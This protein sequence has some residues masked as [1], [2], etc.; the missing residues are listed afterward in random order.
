MD[1]G[2]RLTQQQQL[3]QKLNPAQVRFG[4]LLE[5]SAPE[6][7]DEIRRV[8]DE[9][10]ALEILD[11]TSE[12]SEF[13]DDPGESGFSET[14]DDLVRADY[15]DPDDIPPYRLRDMASHTAEHFETVT[16]AEPD[17]AYD[18]L[19]RQL[20]EVNLPDTEREIAT[21]IIGNLD[22]NG[23]LTRTPEEIADDLA[24]NIGLDVPVETVR[25]AWQS[26]RAL[27]PA[28]IG[29]A[30]L[31]DCLILQL[32][33]RPASVEGRTALEILRRHF[34]LFS[35][36]R[37]ERIALALDIPENAVEQAL[38]LIK[39]LN[40]KPGALLEQMSPSDR[41]RYIV[42][43]FT[44]DTDGAGNVTVSLNGNVPD[45]AVE[46]SFRLDSG[47]AAGPDVEAFV[48]ARR[49]EAV[50]FINLSQMR[51]RT[52]MAV[53]QAIVK[54]Q[55][56]F[57]SGCGRSSIRPMVLRDVQRLTGLDLSVISRATAT[58][59]VSTPR[60]IFPLKMFFSESVSSD[61]DASQHTVMEAIAEL[62]KAEDPA[63]PLSDGRLAVMLAGRGL[64]VAR[65]TVAKYRECLG[66]PVARLR[67]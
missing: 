19:L 3:R 57:F 67:R 27:D 56:P 7:E 65:R 48:S 2:F 15:A 60:G 62:V 13:L 51:G 33:R 52:L 59:Y 26:V 14:S 64:N 23:Y 50:D 31:R 10:P 24:F 12:T 8:A 5:M 40:P 9:N 43:D 39:T 38:D 22:S 34:D 35:K 58:K 41:L 47:T 63:H 16:P 49:D 17:S 18:D 36:K 54:L 21:Y 6:F 45:M 55:A 66:I 46:K 61:S 29:A 44:V 4:R 28:G 30:D 20:A 42:P 53:M 37:P 11:H 25:R 1:S 32:E